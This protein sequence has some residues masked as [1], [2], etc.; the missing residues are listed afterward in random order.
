MWFIR[1]IRAIRDSRF[2]GC[3]LAALMTWRKMSRRPAQREAQHLGR[4]G[5]RVEFPA[6]RYLL[7]AERERKVFASAA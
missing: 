2:F 6:A 1:V 3:G 5:A 4:I 7:R